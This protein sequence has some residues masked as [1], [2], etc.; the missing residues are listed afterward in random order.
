MSIGATERHRSVLG[1]R[2]RVT[3]KHIAKTIRDYV[4]LF[5]GEE[6]ELV[7]TMMLE[8]FEKEEKVFSRQQYDIREYWKELPIWFWKLHNHINLQLLQRQK[9]K[10]QVTTDEEEQITWPSLNA[11]RTCQSS[12]NGRRHWNHPHVFDFLKSQYW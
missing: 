9:Q 7:R 5:L 2:S 1:D 11:C 6:C 8:F 3:T 10:E 12:K 4:D